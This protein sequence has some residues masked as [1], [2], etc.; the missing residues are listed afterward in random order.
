M[1]TATEI[2]GFAKKKK[3]TYASMFSEAQGASRRYV[4]KLLFSAS[5]ARGRSP[6]G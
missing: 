1:T 5:F 3:K 2:Q 6:R 4:G